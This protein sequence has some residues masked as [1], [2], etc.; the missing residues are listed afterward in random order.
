MKYKFLVLDVDGVLVKNK[1]A[2]V[3]SKVIA[4]IK[5]IKDKVKITLCT[6]RTKLDAQHIIDSLD[7]LNNYH[8]IESGAKILAPNGMYEYEKLLS[9][10]DIA[11]IFSLSKKTIAHIAIC[12]RGNWIDYHEEEHYQNVTTVSL[13]SHSQAQTKKILSSIA[14][15][16]KTYHIAVGSHW[17]IPEGNFILITNKEASKQ[18]GIEYLQHKYGIS[19]EETIA[20]GD[21]PNDIPLFQASGFKI[22]MEN[23]D[24]ELKKQADFITKSIDDDGVAYAISVYFNENCI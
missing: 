10:T 24:E 16:E 8:V 9:S 7:I 23:G 14:N 15:L 17:Q 13:H 5:M 3:S 22:A 11:T 18:F 20:I 1:D 19:K 12:S 6:G 2:A 4:A 21:M